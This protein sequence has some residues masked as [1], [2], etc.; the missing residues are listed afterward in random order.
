MNET[1]QLDNIKALVEQPFLNAPLVLESYKTLIGANYFSGAQVI[2]FRIRLNEYDD[3]FTNKIDGFNETLKKWVP[4]LVEHFC[5]M[6]EY[7]GF[8]MRMDEGTLL[9]HVIEHLAIE[10]QNMAGMDVGFGKTRETKEKGV[11]NVVIRFFDEYAGIYTGKMA[12]HIINSILTHQPCDIQKIVQN[13]I[14]IREKRLLGFSTQQ[15]V[16]EAEQR[17]IPTQRLDEF[18]LVQLGTGC[19]RKVIRATLTQ[20]TSYLAVENTDDKYLTYR[21]LEEMGVPVPQR[22]LTSKVKDALDFFHSLQKPVVIKP[23]NGYRGKRVNVHL[24]TEEK[25]IKAF[26]WAQ[27]YEMDVI[28][29]EFV[30]GNTYRILVIDGKYTAAVQLIAPFIMGDGIKTIKELIDDFNANPER[31]FGDKG[32]LSKVDIDE[33]TLKIIDIKG[34]TLTSI[35]EKDKKLFLKNSG[36]M[37]LGSTSVDVTEQVHPYNRFV[38]ERISK[39]LHLDVTG[40]DIISK[41]IAIS[42][43]ENEGRVIEINAAPDFRMHIHPTVGISRPVQ[44]LFVDMLFPDNTPS[45]IP[46][47]SVTGSK[48]KTFYTQLLNAVIAQRGNVVGLLNSNGIFVNGQHLRQVDTSDSQNVRIILKDPS[49]NFAIIETPVESIL[50]HGL[51]YRYA[52][53]GV[54]LNLEEQDIYYTYDHIRDM[55]DVAYAKSVVVEEIDINGYAILNADYPLI[56]DAQERIDVKTAYFSINPDSAVI[57][58]L[59]EK[60]KT[61][62]IYDNH[63]IIIYKERERFIPCYLDEIPNIPQTEKYMKDVLLALCLTLHLLSWNEIDI[64]EALKTIP[65]NYFA[66]MF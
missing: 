4:S 26:F 48:G 32:K 54:I 2:R 63:Q 42:L 21:M 50:N 15:I 5:S 64:R 51:G 61:C 24:D 22:I 6:N 30:S 56:L 45:A 66:K 34:Y 43:H 57:R 3:V 13:L 41:D 36:N 25:I 38:C 17:G 16:N 29:Q 33:D 40:V 49:V 8:F 55:E 27:T 18:N 10:L 28:V 65:A 52:N 39:V 44:K 46:L 62:A 11:Y 35:L 12:L 20:N 19:Y 23:S 31:E 53:I 7:G 9:G 60:N 58:E 59:I 1:G 37:R 47:I 14:L